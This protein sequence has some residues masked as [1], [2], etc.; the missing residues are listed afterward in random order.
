LLKAVAHY[1]LRLSI[2]DED[3]FEGGFFLKRTI[4]ILLA[5]SL[6]LAFPSFAFASTVPIAPLFTHINTITAALSINSSGTATCDGR[7]VHFSGNSA[8][9]VVT[10]Q[11][12]RN[13]S[14][15][16]F[17]EWETTGVTMVTLS[18]NRTVARGFRYRVVVT[19][20]IYDAAGKVLET[21]SVTS[22]ERSW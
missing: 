9:L 20:T 11:Q 19:A 13:G 18:R 10:L 6:F 4:S 16:H 12:Q 22:P 3:N 7:V 1:L 8:K 5:L 21:A 15:H 14:W 17:D 2:P